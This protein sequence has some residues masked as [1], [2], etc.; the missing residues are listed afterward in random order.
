M[1]VRHVKAATQSSALVLIKFKDLENP[2]FPLSCSYKCC[3][4]PAL[5]HKQHNRPAQFTLRSGLALSLVLFFFLNSPVQLV[6][7]SKWRPGEDFTF[8][9]KVQNVVV[10]SLVFWCSVLRNKRMIQCF[11]FESGQHSMRSSCDP[12]LRLCYVCSLF[13]GQFCFEF[14]SSKAPW[15]N[16]VFP[17]VSWPCATHTLYKP[18]SSSRCSPAEALLH[19]GLAACKLETP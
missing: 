14:I 16:I 19:F 7:L 8:S 3:S 6:K 2:L 4:Q 15:E 9:L 18:H 10:Y 11:W 13:R 5:S 17:F 1:F 12:V